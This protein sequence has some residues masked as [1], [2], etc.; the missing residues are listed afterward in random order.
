MFRLQLL[1]VVCE[2]LEVEEALDMIL[3]L[4]G[5]AVLIGTRECHSPFA[6]C[7]VWVALRNLFLVDVPFV[8]EALSDC[9]ER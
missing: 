1:R 6:M 4:L 8:G 7:L 9:R 5:R 3:P 2:D